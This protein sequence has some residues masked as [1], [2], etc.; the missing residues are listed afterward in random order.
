MTTAVTEVLKEDLETPADAFDMGAGRINLS[1]SIYAPIT[2]DE[3]ADNFF[4]MGDDPVQA[5]DLNIPSINAPL[6]PGR[7]ITTRVAT[8]TSGRR[9]RFD[10]WTDAPE[11]ASIQVNPRRFTV[12]A[13]QSVT[14]TIIIES[15]APL[16]TQQFG[17]V[18][19]RSRG[20]TLHLPVAWV[21]TQGDVNLSQSCSP[22]TIQLRGLSTCT[23]EAANN[24]FDDSIVDLDT[25]TSDELHI[26]ATQ[27][28]QFINRHHARRHNVTLSGAS[29]GVPSVDPG[30]SPAGY[31]P[32]D[33]FGFTPEPIGDEEIINFGV[34]AFSYNGQT[35]DAI[36]VDSNGYLIVGGGTSEDNNCCNLPAGADPARPNNIL[37]PFWTDL[38]GTGAPGIL[39]GVLTDGVS[40]WV[41]FEYRVNVFGTTSQRRFQVWIGLQGDDSDVQDISF[42]YSAAQTDP[43]G[44]DFLVGAENQLGQGDVSS[45][46]PG[47]DL[48]VTSTDFTPGDVFTYS[49]TVR[50]D[51]KGTEQV[52]TEMEA[53][54]IPGTT[55]VTTDIRIL[56]RPASNH[57]R[58]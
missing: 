24:S 33:L 22:A 38:D 39:A 19:M 15:D 26:R 58:R 3:T 28:A 9:E 41:I 2:F 51:R 50:G 43:A 54:G 52:R 49:V 23:I 25:F 31:L 32:L 4:A 10:V 21:H 48:V 53:T 7:L 16:G 18:W 45:F 40:E 14:L 47:P 6:M 17:T 29:P 30:A 34:P 5:V 57:H 42:T 37:A 20:A 44:Q 8:N 35:W 12:G 36:G 1:E 55:I 11:G 56:K 27:N 13:G 46:L